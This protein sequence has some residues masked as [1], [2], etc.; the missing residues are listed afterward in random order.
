MVVAVCPAMH[1][2]ALL[3]APA[4]VASGTLSACVRSPQVAAASQPAPAAPGPIPPNASRV[5]ATVL[6]RAVRPPGSLRHLVPSVPSDRTLYTLTIRIHEAA[7]ASP[8]LESYAQP[9]LTIETFSPEEPSPDLVGTRI[10]A[11]LTLTGS[12]DGVRW[13]IADVRAVP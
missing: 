12:T 3:G 10:T 11:T 5:V 9:A 13:W 2:W 4:L 7:P 1:A 8:Q 6:G